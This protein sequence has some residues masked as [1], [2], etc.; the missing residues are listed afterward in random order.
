MNY[1]TM[2]EPLYLSEK[3]N[4]NLKGPVYFEQIL[5]GIPLIQVQKSGIQDSVIDFSPMND[6]CVPCHH[7]TVFKFFLCHVEGQLNL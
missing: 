4:F 5:C 6:I 2:F 3:L 1:F 7:K